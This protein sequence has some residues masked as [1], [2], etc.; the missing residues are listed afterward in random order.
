MVYNIRYATLA[1]GNA[2]CDVFADAYNLG[3]MMDEEAQAAIRQ[4]FLD[5][6]PRFFLGPGN[7]GL[8]L[9]DSTKGDKVV[10][11]AIWEGPDFKMAEVN[12]DAANK[13]SGTKSHPTLTAFLESQAKENEQHKEVMGDAPHWHLHL[14]AVS[15]DY[16]GKGLG[17][18][19]LRWGIER[20]E[21]D[22]LPQFMIASKA[23]RYLYAKHGF[24]DVKSFSFTDS[25]E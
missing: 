15:H 20:A 8:V 9:T 1:D 17:G 16:M 3:S 19:L 18:Q 12:Q 21:K 7:H 24:E 25:H 23:G 22:G 11:I 13:D 10:A 4:Y 5:E 6:T 2:L 14:L